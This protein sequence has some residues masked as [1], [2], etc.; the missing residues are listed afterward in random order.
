[1]TSRNTSLSKIPQN[2]AQAIALSS[3][4]AFVQLQSRYVSYSRDLGHEDVAWYN[5]AQY[6]RTRIYVPCLETMT[7][8]LSITTKERYSGDL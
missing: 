2:V 3:P 1:M 4:S 5:H 7:T 6:E 8:H